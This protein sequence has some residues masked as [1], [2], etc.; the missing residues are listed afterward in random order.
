MSW[1]NI[2]E[3]KHFIL[4]FTKY[5]PHRNVLISKLSNIKNYD[6]QFKT[7]DEYIKLETE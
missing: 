7:E 5:E 4:H 6:K 2:E 3:E 1:S